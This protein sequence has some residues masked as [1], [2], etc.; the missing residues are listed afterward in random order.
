MTDTTNTDLVVIPTTGEA[1]ELN[2]PD[3]V[4]AAYIDQ[5]KDLEAQLREV[6]N[7]IGDELIGR[8]DQ[9]ASW[10]LHAGKFK[11]TAP[12]PELKEE[13]DVDALRS[14][15]EL[16]VEEGVVGEPAAK[17]AIKTEVTYKPVAA[18]IKALRKVLPGPA[19]QAVDSCRTLVPPR[20]TVR[21]E[22][23]R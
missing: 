6:R 17:K 20:R 13:W 12:S 3:D 18:G 1:L 7:R 16:L 10:T 22:F 23:N 14:L 15:L 5:I 9:Q 19:L 21:V 4:L 2:A 8:M 11:V